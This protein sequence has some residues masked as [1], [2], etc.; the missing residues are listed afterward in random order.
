MLKLGVRL[1]HSESDIDR[2]KVASNNFGFPTPQDARLVQKQKRE[3][4]S[5]NLGLVHAISDSLSFVARTSLAHKPEGFSAFSGNPALAR[6]DDERQWANEVG[7]TFGPREGRFGGS[8][9]GFWNRIRGYQFERT[10]PN[11]TDFVVVNAEE[12]ISRGVE[13]K[14]MWNPVERIWWDFQAGY[15]EAE[16]EKHSD[17]AGTSVK[18]RRVPFIPQHTLLTGVTVDLGQ[19][20]SANA[21]YTAVGRTFY[22]ERNTGT[23]SQK[24]YGLVNAQLRYRFDRWAVTLYGHNLFEKDY[25]QFINP[26][27][28]AGS[29][30]SPRRYG[31]RLSFE[32]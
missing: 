29:P 20:F 26:E 6:F 5:A 9:L 30:G 3:Y 17:A 28:F 13:A 2:T 10:V 32:Y 15:T 14:F 16:F 18:G 4:V 8:V 12:V 31:V 7:I 11:S 21:S 25:Y 27:I 22:D 24:S 1:E 19:G 23:F